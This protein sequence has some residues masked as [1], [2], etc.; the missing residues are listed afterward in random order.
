MTEKLDSREL[1]GFQEM[2]IVNSIQVDALA[3]LLI[4]K[5]IITKNDYFKKL[6]DVQQIYQN[7]SAT[8]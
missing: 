6:T 2:L 7:K 1:V 5:G 8:I 4:E 3:Q